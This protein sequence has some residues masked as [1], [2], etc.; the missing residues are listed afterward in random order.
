MTR[1]R[2]LAAG[3]IV[4]AVVAVP[5]GSASVNPALPLAVP[6]FPFVKVLAAAKGMGDPSPSSAVWVASTRNTAVKA[7]MDGS[8]VNSNQPVDVAVL[9]GQFT[10]HN[11]SG[12]VAARPPTGTV[13][14]FVYDARTGMGTD[15]GLSNQQ[16]DL[17]KLGTVHAFLPYL[18]QAALGTAVASNGVA[19]DVPASIETQWLERLSAGTRLGCKTDF[20]NLAPTVFRRR[21]AQAAASDGFQVANLQFLRACESAPLLTLMTSDPQR[22]VRA[23]PQLERSLDRIAQTGQTVWAYEGILINATDQ[24]GR[25][26]VVIWNHVRAEI[27]GGQWASSSNLYPFPHG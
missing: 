5:A 9:T 13:A 8:T 11:A 7:T 6:P 15:F 19:G 21:L 1:I 12:P 3:A 26:F 22:L 14:T 23:L 24:N 18:A 27:A 4:V 16:P 25:S 10:D 2:T 17:A 20:R